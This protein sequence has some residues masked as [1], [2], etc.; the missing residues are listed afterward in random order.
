MYNTVFVTMCLLPCTAILKQAHER[1]C[2]NIIITLH[3]RSDDT[4]IDTQKWNCC[5]IVV[6]TLDLYFY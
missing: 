4:S 2:D 5:Y 6:L 3:S 1:R